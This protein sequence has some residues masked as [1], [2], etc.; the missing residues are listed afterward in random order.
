MADDIRR[1]SDDL[2][3]DPSSLVFMPLAEALRRAG[4][5]DVALRVALRGLDRHPYVADAHDVLARI[6]ADRGDLERAADEWEMALRL[7]PAHSQAN[8]GL[9]FVDYRRGNF[10]SA[11]R[12]LS[13]V[14]E[15]E[16]NPGLAAALAHVRSA[17]DSKASNGSTNGSGAH[18]E[19][20][21][22]NAAAAP[23]AAVPAAHPPPLP[24]V[25]VPEYPA[26][27]P[28][29]A[30]QLF[31]SAL[32][33]PDQSALLVDADGL[34]LAGAYMDPT[35][36]DVADVVAAELA[37]VSSEAERAMRHLGLGAWTSL[38]VEADDAVVAL[39][40]APLGSVLVVSASR[41]TPVGLVRLLLD[42]ALTRAR[43]WLARVS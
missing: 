18:E 30:K 42:R 32:D 3:R 11:E 9:G 24:V 15:T 33:A 5:L 10:E 36:T 38:L 26:P 21:V 23:A 37:G 35:G 41:A 28:D 27:K 4:Q 31:A 1:L 2:A 7:D 25:A 43:D 12:R 6:H 13:A 16:Q 17:L 40:P 14:G 39:T 20:V 22:P 8:L 34:V 19:A 29:R